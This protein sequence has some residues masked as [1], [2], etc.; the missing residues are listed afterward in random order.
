MAHG[1]ADDAPEHVA[2]LLVRGHDAVGDEERHRATV[3]REDPQRHVGTLTREAAVLDAR[4]LLRGADE[5]PEH[6][7]VPDRLDALEHGEVAVEAGAGVDAR[8]RERHEITVGLGVVLHEHEV[9][10][11]DVPILVGGRAAVDPERRTQVPED[12]RVRPAGSGVGHAPEVRRVT[13]TLD[14]L[15]REPDVV[16]PDLLG[17]VIGLVDRDPQPIGVETEHLR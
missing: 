8:R 14:A 10:E 7:G 3:L 17:L 12:L 9:P 6:I 5:R 15:G 11:L 4:D 1:A 2:T 13:E 16:P